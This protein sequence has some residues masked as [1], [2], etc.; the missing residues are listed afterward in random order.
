MPLDASFAQLPNQT[1][2]VT[3]N[4]SMTLGTSLKVLESQIKSSLEDGATHVILNMT[5]VNYMDSAG[6]GLI[7]FTNAE[8]TSKNGSL[9][10][11]GVNQRLHNLFERTRTDAILKFDS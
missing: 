11:R 8:L 5:A 1:V 7:V 4:G 10:L 9:L 6:L 3:L 2:E